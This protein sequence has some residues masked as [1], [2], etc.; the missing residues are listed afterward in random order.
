MAAEFPG[1]EVVR[2][3]VLTA[4][5]G[6]R[7]HWWCEDKDGEIL[8]PTRGQFP[9]PFLT[10]EPHVEGADVRLGKCMQCGTEIWGPEELGR[11]TFC[12]AGCY[13]AFGEELGG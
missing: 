6:R 11:A 9:T 2:G 3:Y 4:E 13:K 5:W 8:D 7:G 1:L 12:D 10:Y